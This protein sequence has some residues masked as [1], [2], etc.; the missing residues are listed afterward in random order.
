L[1]GDNAHYIVYDKRA[2]PL[3]AANVTNPII[4]YGDANYNFSSVWSDWNGA[5]L[6]TTELQGT[7]PVAA[8][9]DGGGCLYYC[10][11]DLTYNGVPTVYPYAGLEDGK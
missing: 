3:V 2:T 1:C 6:F 7:V 5:G 11:N 9:I 10:Y 4:F 8:V